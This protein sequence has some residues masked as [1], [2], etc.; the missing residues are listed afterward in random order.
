MDEFWDTLFQH[1]LAVAFEN[2]MRME[3][4][5]SE[6]DSPEALCLLIEAADNYQ[7][8]EEWPEEE[9][10]HEYFGGSHRVQSLQ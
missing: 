5:V 8:D 9:K 1:M 2:V 6:Y 7:S 3:E 4:K 10:H